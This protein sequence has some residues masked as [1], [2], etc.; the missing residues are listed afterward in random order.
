MSKRIPHLSARTAATAA[1]LMIGHRLV[2]FVAGDIRYGSIERV[3]SAVGEGAMAV[4]L[5]HRYLA[6]HLSGV[7]SDLPTRSTG[8]DDAT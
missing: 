2:V 5:V 7:T 6:N 3:A 1:A 4:T 8:G